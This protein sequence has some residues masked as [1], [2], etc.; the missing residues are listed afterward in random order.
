[1]VDPDICVTAF[2]KAFDASDFHLYSAPTC[3]DFGTA[4]L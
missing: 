1:M 4:G 3:G 2:R